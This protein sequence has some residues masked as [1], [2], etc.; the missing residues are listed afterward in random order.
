MEH[1]EVDVSM[2]TDRFPNSFGVADTEVLLSL[3]GQLTEGDDI[4]V[5]RVKN[6]ENPVDFGAALNTELETVPEI[7]EITSTQAG[8]GLAAQLGRDG[9]GDDR[10]FH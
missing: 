3:L 1:V 10:R 5:T 2:T 6:D 8:E 4:G 9:L 7:Q